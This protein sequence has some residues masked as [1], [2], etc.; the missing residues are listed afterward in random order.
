MKFRRSSCRSLWHLLS[1]SW[2]SSS[3]LFGCSS[4]PASDVEQD[5]RAEAQQRDAGADSGP[6]E[7]D[8]N[9]PKDANG[10][11][12]AGAKDSGADHVSTQTYPTVGLYFISGAQDYGYEQSTLTAYLEH[13]DAVT[14]G[15]DWEGNASGYGYSRESVVKAV[16]A[17]DGTVFPL[18]CQYD[19][20]DN[21]NSAGNTSPAPETTPIWYDQVEAMSSWWYAWESGGSGTHVTLPDDS[22]IWVTN[23]LDNGPPSLDA[24][25]HTL[26]EAAAL[27][28]YDY[29]FGGTNT[30]ADAA[31]SLG[32][33][34]HDNF[35]VPA[36]GTVSGD[37]QHTGT[38]TPSN[39]YDLFTPYMNSLNGYVT[40]W[41]S[42]AG[43]RLVVG[44]VYW[45][46]K[47]TDSDTPLFQRSDAKTL[48][49]DV[50]GSLDS[51]LYE[52]FEGMSW[53]DETQFGVAGMIPSIQFY[54]ASAKNPAL[55]VYANEGMN[56]SGEDYTANETVGQGFRYY[57]GLVWVLT[58]GIAAYMSQSDVPG[59]DYQSL[60]WFDWYSVNPATGEALC[61]SSSTPAELGQYRKWMGTPIDEPPTTPNYDVA[62]GRR[63]RTPNARTVLLLV[64]P[65]AN[66][67]SGAKT[68]TG[69]L[70]PGKWQALTA[71]GCSGNL[72]SNPS[73]DD[74]AKGLTTFSVPIADA[75]IYIQ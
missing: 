48:L 61:Y 75:R 17:G 72:G 18:V 32:C 62:Y 6:S 50:Y 46:I 7:P 33:M 63:F 34:F 44:N 27:Y 55:N 66:K 3:A 23:A 37:W 73:V 11:G 16:R 14:L 58:H 43:G 28:A 26:Q 8:A 42:V 57:L 36:G 49:G 67:N 45:G 64:N 71:S 25:G 38:A 59:N 20:F 65:S 70:P 60:D 31:P 10:I 69:S 5:A 47:L 22:A 29:Y 53:A 30:N 51:E 13:F 35:Q 4:G 52:G 2:I 15:G 40:E 74:G 12:D 1:A 19:I 41:R 9:R 54:E 68:A 21:I 56:R 24:H 39:S